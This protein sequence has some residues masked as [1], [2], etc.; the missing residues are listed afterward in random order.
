MRIAVILLL[1]IAG[2]VVAAREA[3]AGVDLASVVLQRCETNSEPE[4]R[5]AATGKDAKA[6]A[7]LTAFE[8]LCLSR[9][10]DWARLQGKQYPRQFFIVQYG[11]DVCADLQ[12]IRVTADIDMQETVAAVCGTQTTR[13]TS[14]AS[15]A[16]A[17]INLVLGLGDLLQAEAKQ[18]ALEYLLERIGKKFCQYSF[19]IDLPEPRTDAPGVPD[20]KHV[21]AMGVWFKNSCAVMLPDGAI[22]VDAFTFGALKAAFKQDLRALPPLIAVPAQA[23]IDR[24]WPGA[25]PYIAAVGVAMYVL[26]DVLQ[27][28]T[29]LEILSDLGDKADEALK[30]KV[31]CDLTARAKITKECVLLLGFDL[32][33]AA[34]TAYSRDRTTPPSRIIADALDKFC[35][36]FGA[37]GLQ[38]HGACVVAVDEYEQWHA[39]LLAIY[40]AIKR[41]QDLDRTMAQLASE[42]TRDEISKRVASEIVHAI[43]QLIDSLAAAAADALPDERAR[44]IEDFALL[45]LAFDAFDA[46]IADDPAALGRTLL[47]ALSSKMGKKRVPAEVVRA[48]TVVVA[49]ASAKDREEVKAILKDVTAPVG[50][51][52]RKYGAESVTI[53]LN[54]FVGFFVGEE[55][56]VNSREPDGTPRDAVSHLAPWKLSAP[57]GVDFSLVS[58]GRCFAFWRPGTCNHVG[59][60]ATLID[61]LALAVSTENDTLSADW[62]TLFT[63]GVYVRFGVLRSPFTIAIGANYQWGRRSDAMCGGERCFDGAFQFGALLS[64]DVPLFVLR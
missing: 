51:Y 28:M 59:I 40:R 32:A 47:A 13:E 10:V 64:A 2:S 26:Y 56:R 18:E 6:R 20:P 17:G 50:T 36:D 24:R 39:R 54:G 4:Y 21:I 7:R 34:A 9:K 12:L 63:P 1:S 31:K 3:H 30:G 48:L 33:R 44:I 5:R 38:D 55:L 8:N 27:G 15:F 35:A 16:G 14:A 52:R 60:V 37:T 53:S 29:P 41:M 25:K 57:V 46:I 22:D 19:T 49:L 62:K 61:P 11:I 42:A 58:G 23:W 43:R 45:G